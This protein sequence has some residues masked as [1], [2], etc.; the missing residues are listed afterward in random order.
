MLTRDVELPKNPPTE[1]IKEKHAAFLESYAKD[2]HGFEQTMVEYLRMS[3]IYWS[4]TAME[5]MGDGYRDRLGNREE[6]LSF[7]S[8][9]QDPISGGISPSNGHDPHILHTLSAIQILA[10][11]DALNETPPIVDI[12]KVVSYIKSLQQPDGSFFGDK[13]G[14]VDLRF[15]FCAIACLS[16]LHRLDEINTESAVSF[17]M[18]CNNTID[19]G[20]GS[21]PGSESHAGLIYCAL[22]SLSILGR[23]DLIDA[24]NLGWWLAE[25]QLP[26]SGGLNGRPE[27]LPDL[28][29][30]WWVLSSLCILGRLRWIHPQ[31]LT[32]FILACQDVETGGF[33]DR[34]GNCVDPFHTCFGLTGLSLLSHELVIPFETSEVSKGGEGDSSSSATSKVTENILETIGSQVKPVNAVFC[35]PQEVIDRLKIR[36]EMLSL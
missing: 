20:F 2:R 36:V 29:Y 34:P 35:M 10:M 27:K 6:L 11:M 17:I 21:R 7:I 8:S 16:L 4:L 22:G 28:C 23:L 12:D 31:R 25:R 3:G 19:G 26:T 32:Q 18:S 30:S 33:S 9:C 24:D 5:I 15:S 13:W 14:E 1:L